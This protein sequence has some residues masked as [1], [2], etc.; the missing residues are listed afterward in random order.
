MHTPEMQAALRRKWADVV[1]PATGHA[2]YADMRRAVN[3]ELG[4]PQSFGGSGGS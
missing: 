4:R 3:A 2:C 1:L